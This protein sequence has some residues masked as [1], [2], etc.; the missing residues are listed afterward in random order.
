MVFDF[1][2]TKRHDQA[3]LFQEAPAGGQP[4]P[5]SLAGDALLEPFWPTGLGCIRGFLG[6]MDAV[7]CEE[8]GGNIRGTCC[9]HPRSLSPREQML[10][11][12]MD[13]LAGIDIRRTFDLDGS[14]FVSAAV[15]RRSL[16]AFDPQVFNAHCL[17]LLLGPAQAESVRIQD[18]FG[19][20][21]QPFCHR[22]QLLEEKLAQTRRTSQ[23]RQVEL[24][25][26]AQ[27]TADAL[28][29][30]QRE[31]AQL[32]PHNSCPNADTQDDARSILELRERLAHSEQQRKKMEEQLRKMSRAERQVPQKSL[33]LKSAEEEGCKGRR[34]RGTPHWHEE[35]ADSMDVQKLLSSEQTRKALEQDLR[36]TLAKLEESWSGERMPCVFVNHG[37]GPLPLL[38]KQPAIAKFLQGYRRSLPRAPAAII[39]VTAHWET[40]SALKVTA[41]SRHS[42]YFDYGGFPKESYEYQY[43]AAG[44]PDLA[45]Q[46]VGLLAKKGVQCSTDTARG[47]DHGVFVPMMLMFPKADI[48]LVALS[49]YSNQDARA[50]MAA[51]EALQPLR[52]QGVLILGSGASFHNF[53]YFFARD[54]SRRLEGVSHS[55]KFDRWLT[56]TM[57]SEALTSEERMARL[58]DW[59]S[60]P[61]ARDAQPLGAAEHLMPL[62]VVAGAAGYRPGRKVNSEANSPESLAAERDKQQLQRSLHALQASMESKPGSDAD[63]RADSE[64]NELRRHDA[65]QELKRLELALAA[66]SEA[67]RRQE[68]Q[69]RELSAQ[70]EELAAQLK[71]QPDNS[72][73]ELQAKLRRM[74]DEVIQVREVMATREREAVEAVHHAVCRTKAELEEPLRGS[75]EHLEAKADAAFD[76]VT[77]AEAESQ[78]LAECMRQISGELAKLHLDLDGSQQ[79]LEESNRRAGEATAAAAAAVAERDARLSK[80]QSQQK[81]SE[82]RLEFLAGEIIKLKLENATLHRDLAQQSAEISR[83]E[84]EGRGFQHEAARSSKQAETLRGELA[85]QLAQLQTVQREAKDLARELE[86]RSLPERRFDALDGEVQRLDG[87]LQQ[88]TLQFL[89]SATTS[90]DLSRVASRLAQ[91]ELQVP[92]TDPTERCQLQKELGTVT[93]ELGASRAR[94]EAAVAEKQVL[95]ARLAEALQDVEEARKQREEKGWE[96]AEAAAS[97]NREMAR[98]RSE[99]DEKYRLLEKEHSSVR[100]KLQ[101]ALSELAQ[102]ESQKKVLELQVETKNQQLSDLEERQERELAAQAEKLEQ[103]QVEVDRLTTE[104]SKASQGSPAEEFKRAEELRPRSQSENEGSEKD[105]KIQELQ[106]QLDEVSQQLNQVQAELEQRSI[107]AAEA[108]VDIGQDVDAIEWESGQ[109]GR[110]LE[111]QI[112]EITEM[113]K[114]AE[115]TVEALS[116]ELD[117]C[118]A[119]LAASENKRKELEY[120]LEEKLRFM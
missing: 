56:E 1:S 102:A 87:R 35:A 117:R 92:E 61:S 10:V 51:G 4:L 22:V 110:K 46:I 99:S 59:A 101:S 14:G 112:A 44:S 103:M 70:K 18:V 9:S 65:E 98:Q 78:D 72:A 100:D 43:S 11:Q 64:R 38:G 66:Q 106:A 57:T 111:A 71:R 105:R 108:L 68:Q 32:Q 75:V 82:N 3:L 48:P 37:G 88:M 119:K 5:I 33:A 15:L 86:L 58:S 95:E 27:D 116:E 39:V 12:A 41:A 114:D 109:R 93:G 28:R 67:C 90:D 118:N 31:L 80:A 77:R 97:A 19:P 24:A 49:L 55:Q 7:S 42:L 25:Q 84:Q 54:P 113:E 21:W 62:F 89:S 120:H 36:H 79:A 20:F 76:R 73:E 13:R 47:W 94:L 8:P 81:E 29:L 63:G 96:A 60:A 107:E 2:D 6:A 85:S 53:D 83:L 74:E 34:K 16:S 115:E 69:L 23:K 26:T 91:T 30:A 50:H 45:Q 52:D 104:L 40:G 17:Q